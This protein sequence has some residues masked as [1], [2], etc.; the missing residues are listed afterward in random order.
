MTFVLLQMEMD[1]P[2]LKIR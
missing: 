2:N 1:A